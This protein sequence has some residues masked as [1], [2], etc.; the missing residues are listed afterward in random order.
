ITFLLQGLMSEDYVKNEENRS[1]LKRV[2]IDAVY[3][4]S[5]NPEEIRQT[6]RARVAYN[7]TMITM[8]KTM[9]QAN[10]KILGLTKKEALAYSM[11]LD[12]PTKADR[13]KV[14]ADIKARI[15][16]NID[17]YKDGNN[18]DLRKVGLG[19]ILRPADLKPG[20]IFNLDYAETVE[21]LVQYSSE[22]DCIV[23]AHGSESNAVITDEK[24][25]EYKQ[26]TEARYEEQYK[27]ASDAYYSSGDKKWKQ[28][29]KT[30]DS[31]DSA[32][33]KLD[34]LYWDQF[35]LYNKLVSEREYAQENLQKAIERKAYAA[36]EFDTLR[37]QYG[38]NIPERSR[39]YAEHL[40]KLADDDI[41]EFETVI[42][43]YEK[44]LT[45]VS[46][47]LE[48]LRTLK[49]KLEGEKKSR[50]EETMRKEEARAK[51]LEK[52]AND[53]FNA[54]FD[55]ER[56][57]KDAKALLRAYDKLAKR[58]SQANIWTTMPI[59][60]PGGKTFTVVDDLVRQL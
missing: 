36:A 41:K 43:N 50:I 24:L 16:A 9:L 44:T 48:N 27:K 25:R 35:S 49:T 38:E 57:E 31:F 32:F 2:I 14:T 28:I 46:N 5:D 39:K 34:K 3:R 12:S 13:D 10:Y 37:K 53:A 8:F 23:I 30:E 11:Q 20:E 1:D 26:A 18:W 58:H 7:K 52:K 6:C 29:D 22:Y 54:K 4:P 15:A 56:R 55:M 60:T 21:R 47:E 40:L 33:D 42:T 19:V 17:Q 51:V 45:D 59:K